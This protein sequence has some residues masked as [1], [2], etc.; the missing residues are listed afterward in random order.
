MEALAT[1]AQESNTTNA[2]APIEF[3]TVPDAGDTSFNRAADPPMTE[4]MRYMSQGLWDQN[5]EASKRNYKKLCTQSH[6]AKDDACPA[7]RIY[8][9]GFR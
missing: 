9:V 6:N 5:D 8:P 7:D 2:P 3:H 4:M 1:T